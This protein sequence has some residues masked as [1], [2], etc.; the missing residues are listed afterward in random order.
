MMW[1]RGSGLHISE[2]LSQLWVSSN[3]GYKLVCTVGPLDLHSFPHQHSVPRSC[4]WLLIFAS[5][6][7]SSVEHKQSHRH[8]S[9]RHG[10]SLMVMKRDRNKHQPTKPQQHISY[11]CLRTDNERSLQIT[12]IPN[13]F[14]HLILGTTSF[15]DLASVDF[16]LLLDKIFIKV[17]NHRIMPSLPDSLQPRTKPSFL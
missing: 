14:Y 1:W 3:L 12:K 2:D 9:I 6:W 11:A 5:P 8:R 16:F 10:H 17:L 7:E 4:L 13:I 15:T